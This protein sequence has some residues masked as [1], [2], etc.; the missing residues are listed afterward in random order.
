[1][2]RERS[3]YYPDRF[4][5]QI[6]TGR[7]NTS[8]Y[9]FPYTEYGFEQLYEWMDSDS[10]KA[11]QEKPCKH[12]KVLRTPY[13]GNLD[14]EFWTSA[15][16]T[17]YIEWKTDCR[18]KFYDLMLATTPQLADGW[19]P[20]LSPI[21]GLKQLYVREPGKTDVIL[22]ADLKILIEDSLTAMLPGI[23]PELSLL[24]TLFEL[25]DVTTLS[26]T[27]QRINSARKTLFRA[28]R[29]STAKPLRALL[30]MSADSYLQAQFNILPLLKDIASVRTACLTVEKKVQNLLQDEGRVN[31]RHY[32]RALRDTYQD[33]DDNF[34]VSNAP[35]GV[36]GNSVYSRKSQYDDPSFHATLVYSYELNE[37]QR[38]NADMLGLLDS[39]GVNFNPQI[40]WN[41]IPWSFVVDWVAGVGQWL[42]RNFTQRLLE[43]RT[44]IISYSWSVHVARNVTTTVWHTTPDMNTGPTPLMN[45]R[46][47]TYVRM[48]DSPSLYDS[49]KTSGLSWTESSLA[50]ALAYLKVVH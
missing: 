49:L 14:G 5:K 15:A 45:H 18:S 37:W 28:F 38:A 24:N 41:A 17:G 25:K 39:L 23:K 9:E 21:N 20:F 10:S 26:H 42:N 6:G 7:G 4:G 36:K 2:I 29:G 50:A 1:M 13:S 27:I 40:I 3:Q 43:P 30:G 48:P 12:V 34:T 19:G 31:R 16:T 8:T 44:R 35:W 32:R 33:S 11:F 46:I 22:P 47:E